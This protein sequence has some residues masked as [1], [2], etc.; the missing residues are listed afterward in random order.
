MGA[1]GYGISIFKRTFIIFVSVSLF[2]GLLRIW[3]KPDLIKK[4]FEKEAGLRGII[5]ASFIGTLI[6]G[7]F[8]LI[9]PILEELLSKGAR[10]AAVASIISAWAIKTPWIPYGAAFMGWKFIIFFNIGLF[11]FSLMEGY[12][13]EGLISKGEK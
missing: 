12:I 6:V 11:V 5:M 2:V 1:L 4:L 3:V 13:I 7:P 9:F 8:Y 10:I